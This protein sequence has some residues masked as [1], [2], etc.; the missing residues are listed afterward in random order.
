MSYYA[1]ALAF[2]AGIV[3]SVTANVSEAGRYRQTAYIT[4]AYFSNNTVERDKFIQPDRVIIV[5]R[6]N[7]PSTLVYFVANMLLDEGKHE[8][9]VDLIDRRGKTIHSYKYEPVTAPAHDTA[10]T[11][12]AQ[13]GG[14]APPGSL[15]VKV[16]DRYNGRARA[17]IGAFRVL[18][19]SPDP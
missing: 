4:N 14:K 18:V 9:E 8:I 12:V 13:I 11:T 17:P 10:Y 15:F 3:L 5:I 6:A 19:R 7:E 1:I 2:L 16:F